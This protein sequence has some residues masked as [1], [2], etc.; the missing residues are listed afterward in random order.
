MCFQKLSFRE[1]KKLCSEQ[2]QLLSNR[3][4]ESIITDKGMVPSEDETNEESQSFGEKETLQQPTMN[5]KE[6]KR[7]QVMSWIWHRHY[8]SQTCN[9][10]L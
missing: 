1:V 8:D 5:K 9:N 7:K 6:Q 2:L 4:I 10:L 3:Q